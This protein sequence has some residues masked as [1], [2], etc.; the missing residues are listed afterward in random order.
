MSGN[1]YPFPPLGYAFRPPPMDCILPS[2]VDSINDYATCTA[3]LA[4][5]KTGAAARAERLNDPSY[6]DYVRWF[7][8]FQNSQRATSAYYHA[9]NGHERAKVTTFQGGCKLLLLPETLDYSSSASFE[10]E[11]SARRLLWPKARDELKNTL[12]NYYAGRPLAAAE[13]TTPSITYRQTAK[14]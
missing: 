4:E 13:T 1:G 9:P 2:R 7:D 12:T 3:V 6:N 11:S 5:C 14:W 8:S 10:Q